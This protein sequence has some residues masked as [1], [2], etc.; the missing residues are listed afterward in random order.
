MR[1]NIIIYDWNQREPLDYEIYRESPKFKLKI[2]EEKDEIV[3]ESA[4]GIEVREGS[5]NGRSG[6]NNLKNSSHSAELK[7]GS[8]KVMSSAKLRKITSITT[9]SSAP[10]INSCNNNADNYKQKSQFYEQSPPNGG[11]QHK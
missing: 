10:M 2:D 5:T 11:N 7:P 3:E 9:G 8:G 1:N 6:D 4:S